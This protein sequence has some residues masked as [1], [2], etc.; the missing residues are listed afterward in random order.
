MPY[1][2][3][4]ERVE[5]IHEEY[6]KMVTERVSVDGREVTRPVTYPAGH[7]Q[8]GRPVIFESKEE[9]DAYFAP[10]KPT[11]GKK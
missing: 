6:P 3:H 11:R 2:H 7:A 8:Y 4:P 9:E 1:K 5:Y 10:P